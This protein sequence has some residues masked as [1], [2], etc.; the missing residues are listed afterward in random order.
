MRPHPAGA[1][2]GCSRRCRFKDALRLRAPGGGGD[3]AVT[4]RPRP[5]VMLQRPRVGPG[6]P[7]GTGPE[8]GLR[9]GCLVAAAAGTG[10][11][12]PPARFPRPRCAGGRR[13]ARAPG[14]LSAP[15]GTGT[16]TGRGRVG[17]A[18]FGPGWP[19][20]RTVN[21]G[22]GG[23]LWLREGAG[24]DAHRS[25]EEGAR[26]VPESPGQ[27]SWARAGAWV[28]PSASGRVY[29]GPGAASRRG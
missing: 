4:S 24:G 19:I 28:S 15:P 8:P 22:P 9:R 25:C 17:P 27:V 21:G 12:A 18:P 7:A 1:E 29:P 14:A 23:R 10:P 11:P 20:A 3:A 13:A 2:L 5:A 26:P 6:L 16:G